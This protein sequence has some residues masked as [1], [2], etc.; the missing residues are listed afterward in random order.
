[1]LVQ[2]PERSLCSNHFLGGRISEC[3]RCHATNVGWRRSFWHAALAYPRL[4]LSRRASA[5]VAVSNHAARRLSL[6]S[7]RTIYNGTR[8]HTDA[9]PRRDVNSSLPP[10]IAYVGRLTPDKGVAVLIS[11]AIELAEKGCEFTLRIIGDGPERAALQGLVRF[12]ELRHLIT[13]TG[14]L[15]G[16]D[17]ARA[18]SD[19]VAIVMPSLSEETAGLAAVEQMMNGKLVIASDI[20]GLSEVL[21]STGLKFAPG[22]SHE[23]AQCIRQALE[24]P[25][26][27]VRLGAAARDRA[28]AMF[29]EKRMVSEHLKLYEEVLGLPKRRRRS[30]FIRR[31]SEWSHGQPGNYRKT[32]TRNTS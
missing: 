9:S 32:R 30:K 5:N 8:T 22:N 2:N 20:G 23:L 11:A 17:L 15:E 7:S 3:V 19:A 18:T 4:W 31:R 27:R 29:T 1:L 24:D 14:F 6:P 25:E 10:C 13:F 28:L 16:S 26:M 12:L 21:G